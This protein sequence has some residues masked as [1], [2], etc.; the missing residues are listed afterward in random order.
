MGPTACGKTRAA[1]EFVQQYPCEIISVDSAM[2]YKGLDIG[3]GKPDHA[4]LAIAPHRLIDIR[5]PAEPYSAAEFRTDAIREINAVLAKGKIPLL[6]GGTMLY[7]KVLRDGLA[8]MP[9]AVPAVRQRILDLAE[10]EGWQ[11]VHA[12]LQQVDP[13]A[14]LR[15]HPNDPQRLQRALEVYEITG[16]SLTEL[17][18]EPTAT[19]GEALPCELK[20]VAMLPADRSALHQVIAERFHTMLDQGLVD[21]VAGLRARGDLDKDLPAIRS[22]GYRQVW[23]YLDGATDY[24][25]M[26]EKGIAATRQLAKRQLTWLRSWPDLT[27]LPCTLGVEDANNMKNHLNYLM[28]SPF[29]GG[30]S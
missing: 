29:S 15:I 3:S 30:C 7:F 9:A 12:R 17:H 25:T 26:V 28:V 21:E 4:T 14:A 10:S 27:A 24:A 19:Q 20:F 11:A 22:V 5:D 6:V 23:E 2:V 18:G 13:E 8:S 16:K 1:V